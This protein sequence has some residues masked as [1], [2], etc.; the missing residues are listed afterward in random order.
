MFLLKRCQKLNVDEQ[1][2]N[3]AMTTGSLLCARAPS[4][5]CWRWPAHWGD[6]TKQWHS[7][8]RQWKLSF[9]NCPVAPKCSYA[10]SHCKNFINIWFPIF[11][12]VN[13]Q[14][15]LRQ[16]K[17]EY[18][19]FPLQFHLTWNNT[20]WAEFNKWPFSWCHANI[21]N[22]LVNQPKLVWLSE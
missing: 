21:S 7:V 5:G 4:P 11:C 10:W 16:D 8:E 2:E 22:N 18:L 1:H 15:H 19:L 6:F 13:T 12:D 9:K 3:M 17:P 14:F 20:L